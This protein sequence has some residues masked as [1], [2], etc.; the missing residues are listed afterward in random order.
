MRRLLILLQL[1]PACCLRH[2]PAAARLRPAGAAAIPQHRH[3]AIIGL[4]TQ[5]LVQLL[6]SPAL[7]IREGSSLKLQFRKP[8]LRARRL[9]LSAARRGR[10]VPGQLC[11]RTRSPAL[12]RSIRRPAWPRCRAPEAAPAPSGPLR[13]QPGRHCR[14]CGPTLAMSCGSPLLPAAIRQL[15]IIRLT[16]IRLIGEPANNARNDG[17]VERQQLGPADGDFS[18][19][20][21][22]K[23]RLAE[24]AWAKLFHGQTARQSSQP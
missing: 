4:T 9:S 5:E 16:P 19:S 12:R 20:R 15:R 18:S 21:A 7:Q 11:R 14:R 24:A 8:V 13:R 23:A 22:T 17:V 1:H 6:G 3:G 2:P 10:A